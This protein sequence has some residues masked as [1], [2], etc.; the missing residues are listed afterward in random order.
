MIFVAII[1]RNQPFYGT[2]T[3]VTVRGLDVSVKCEV[4]GLW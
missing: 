1:V 3:K 2:P 4:T